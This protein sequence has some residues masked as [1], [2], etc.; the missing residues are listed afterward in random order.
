[1]LAR[2]WEVLQRDLEMG[3]AVI[4]KERSQ[5]QIDLALH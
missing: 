1:M 5:F 2:E 4:D 3:A